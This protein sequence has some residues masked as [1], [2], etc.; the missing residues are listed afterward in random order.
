MKDS[1]VLTSFTDKSDIASEDKEEYNLDW[2]AARYTIDDVIK[3]VYDV[4]D[5]IVFLDNPYE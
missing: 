3:N 5:C 2:T 4:K 1:E